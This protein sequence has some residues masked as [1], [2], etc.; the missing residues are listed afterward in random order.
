MPCYGLQEGVVAGS[1]VSAF[2]AADA[3]VGEGVDDLPAGS[4]GH[5][6]EDEKLVLD[7]LRILADP[8]IERGSLHLRDDLT[9]V[10]SV[11]EM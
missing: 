7:G 10:R 4:L 8:Y 3:F 1:F 11:N 5:L 9:E 2:G 6:V